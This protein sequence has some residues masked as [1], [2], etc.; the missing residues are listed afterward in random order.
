MEY[1]AGHLSMY[2]IMT[3]VQWVKVL[4]GQLEVH[5]LAL[6][7][8]MEGEGLEGSQFQVSHCDVRAL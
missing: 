7:D 3:L 1:I 2:S 4:R 5:E 6:D 8:A